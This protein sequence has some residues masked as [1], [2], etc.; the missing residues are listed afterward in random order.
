MLDSIVSA[1][2]SFVGGLMNQRAADKRWRSM[3]K[4]L[5]AVEAWQRQNLATATNSIQGSLQAFQSDPRRAKVRAEWDRLLENPSSL[6]DEYVSSVKQNALSGSAKG[7]AASS[8]RLSADAQRRGVG[9]S[10][11]ISTLQGA[12]FSNANRDA[13]NLSA[14]IDQGA[15]KQRFD[16]KKEVLAGYQQY[17]DDDL[18]REYG[19]SKDLAQL[20]GSVNYGNSLA[21]AG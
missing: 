14:S 13:Q 11:Y 6:T 5:K 7:A 21:M 8:K 16:D 9:N 18:S 20:L 1:G 19:Y 4:H 17:T 12:L 15:A 2:A 10:P 3:M